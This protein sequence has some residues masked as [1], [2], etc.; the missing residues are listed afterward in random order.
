[1]HYRRAFIP[2]ATYFFTVVTAHRRPVFRSAL[3]R[4][5]L[6][7]A[8]RHVAKKRP[9]TVNAMVVLPD[10]LHCLWTLPSADADYPTRW[11]LIK[12]GVTQRYR[13]GSPR[14]IMRTLWQAR[15]WEHLIRDDQ[16]YRQHVEYI[17]YNPV[18]HGYVR[19]PVAWPYSSFRQHVRDGL[20]AE[21]WGRTEPE[22][23]G[24]VGRE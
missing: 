15:Y 8:F 12:T 9:F 16:D 10:H 20:Y 14:P 17:H 22:W 5:L 21:D 23:D 7:Q 2:G 1:M 19:K 18:K 4:D 6:R 13:P 3:A 24:E 11:R